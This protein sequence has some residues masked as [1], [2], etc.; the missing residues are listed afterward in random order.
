[1]LEL[2]EKG[3]ISGDKISKNNVPE[4]QK[5]I[6][7]LLSSGSVS[8]YEKI[9]QI[10]NSLTFSEEEKIEILQSLENIISVFPD[11]IG[12][13]NK[14]GEW[15]EEDNILKQKYGDN[16]K[17]YILNYDAQ[18]SKFESINSYKNK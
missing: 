4:A 9:K 12:N 8:L 2:K 10:L 17:N 16:Y 7:R 18:K 6:I 1:M 13:Y 5:I 11:T 3:L 15:V 14:A